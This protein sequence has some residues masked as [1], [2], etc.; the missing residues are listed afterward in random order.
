MESLTA[1]IN[2]L[3][4]YTT[5]STTNTGKQHNPRVKSE[6]TNPN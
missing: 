6:K 1:P 4:S 2:S 3:N 5:K